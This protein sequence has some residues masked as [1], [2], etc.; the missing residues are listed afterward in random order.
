MGS[1][2]TTVPWGTLKIWDAKEVEPRD[3]PL[4]WTTAF[5]V[6]RATQARSLRRAFVASIPASRAGR[7]PQ[8]DVVINM[9]RV[10]SAHCTMHAVF[11]GTDLTCVRLIDM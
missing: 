8:A 11:T 6:G 3:V 9:P 2:P 4:R 7:R 10:S 1:A 5:V